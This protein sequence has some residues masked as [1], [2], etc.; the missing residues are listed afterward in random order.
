MQRLL[1]PLAV[2]LFAL[3]LVLQPAAALRLSCAAVGKIFPQQCCCRDAAPA[4]PSCCEERAPSSAP[5]GAQL[6]NPRA[7]HCGFELPERPATA[8]DSG[9]RASS[10]AKSIASG[11]DGAYG[12]R[13][14]CCES[15]SL[16]VARSW[17]RAGLDDSG[18]GAGADPARHAPRSAPGG[19]GLRRL[20]A[21]HGARAALNALRTA[22]C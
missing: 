20:A 11:S 7:C 18:G 16:D 2:C 6:S 14:L 13:A 8:Q 5:V 17:L 10:S 12:L 19:A 9:T 15:A 1:H 4:R 21:E 22:R 3:A